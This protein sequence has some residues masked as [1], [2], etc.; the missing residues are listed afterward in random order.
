MP[1]KVAPNNSFSFST[2]HS[3]QEVKFIS[4]LLNLGQPYHS[5]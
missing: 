4:P 5:L 3:P 1:A 2:Y